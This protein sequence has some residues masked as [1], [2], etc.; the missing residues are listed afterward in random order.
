MADPKTDPHT[1]LGFCGC[2]CP[3]EAA[4]WLLRLLR[5]LDTR[6]KSAD[7]W[8]N[9]WGRLEQFWAPY[10]GI[11]SPV[12]YLIMYWID[13][14]GWTEHGGS[15]GGSWLEDKGIEAMKALEKLIERE[16]QEE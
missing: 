6:D 10:G 12:Y 5:E 9:R 8:Q 1:L 14:R 7:Y 13:D 2:G 11:D 4:E 16:K 15:V 3:G